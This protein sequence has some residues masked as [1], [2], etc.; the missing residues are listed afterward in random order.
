MRRDVHVG[1]ISTI[2]VMLFLAACFAG[3]TSQTPAATPTAVPT[4]AG[5]QTLV[6]A[7]TTSLYDT[8][9][10][11]YLQQKFEAK[12][13]TVKLKITSQGSGKAIELA[14]NGDADV[15]LVHSPAAELAFMKDG[16]GLNRR[17]FAS[18][19]FMIVGPAADPA[20]VKNMTP[21]DAFATFFLKGSNNTANIYF[22][23]R[24]DGSG[25]QT[26]EKNIWSKAGYN[27]TTQ[28][29]KSGTWYVEAGKGMGETLQ[30]ANEKNAYTLTDEGTYLAYKSN[31]TLVP[32][33]SK[34]A[35]LLNIYSVMAVYN[36]KQPA[37]KIKMA[38][39]FINFLI[40]PATQTDIGTYGVDKYGKALFIPMSVQVPTAAEGW[41]GNYTAPATLIAPPTTGGVGITN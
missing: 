41:V 3:C 22:V 18:N 19:Y 37:D 23:S 1:L 28:V 27:Y 29:E 32:V 40:D 10:L 25:T 36:T 7:T 33:V 13:P 20:G 15:L 9:L 11:D 38:N 12:Y 16:Y 34:G 31:L 24:G 21:E 14:K 39:N 17:T 8:G 5:P 4:A 30:M 6:I 26:A 2:F 35:S